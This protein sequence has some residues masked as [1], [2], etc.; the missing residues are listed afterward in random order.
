MKWRPISELSTEDDVF[1]RIEVKGKK[2]PY[3]DVGG[4]DCNKD[5][6]VQ[7]NVGGAFWDFDH[8]FLCNV[9]TLHSRGITAIY[10]VDPKEIEL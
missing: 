4:I 5:I 7:G 2:N 9:N 10:F 1:L 8:G 6:Y 3:Y